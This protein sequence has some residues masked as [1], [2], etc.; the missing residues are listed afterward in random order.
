MGRRSCAP[1][2]YRAS[3]AAVVLGVPG[4]YLCD[5]IST[6]SVHFKGQALEARG[7]KRRRTKPKARDREAFTGGA[8]L[9][10]GK[11]KA[12]F[13]I[14]SMDLLLLLFKLI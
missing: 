12:G 13:S 6:A 5:S 9:V 4:H 14:G 11:G 1:W 8:R 2:V 10:Q 3:T 7:G